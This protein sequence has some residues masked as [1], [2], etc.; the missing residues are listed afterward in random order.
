[1]IL[2][3]SIN[4]LLSF[5]ILAG[6]TSACVAP[7]DSEAEATSSVQELKNGAFQVPDQSPLA[8]STVHVQRN[9]INNPYSCT[10]VI[11]GAKWV[12]TAAHC[13]IPSSLSAQRVYFYNGPFHTGDYAD[14]ISAQVPPGVVGGAQDPALLV[15]TNGKFADIEVLELSSVIPSYTRIAQ[16]PLLYPGNDV[17]GLM[18]GVGAHDE[19]FVNWDADM[20]QLSRATYSS[21]T[22]DG[23]FLVN[24]NHLLW[25][26]HDADQGDSGGPFLL[27]NN[28]TSRWV[29]Q[30]LASQPVNEWGSWKTKYA[31]IT[32]RLNWVLD[33]ISF[34]GFG[35]WR[36]VNTKLTG[37]VYSSFLLVGAQSRR[38]AL[39]CEHNP[40]CVGYSH[41]G[42]SCSLYSAST[43]T[44]VAVGTISGGKR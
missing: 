44:S 17:T 42:V 5:A 22:Q 21:D 25:E 24:D 11:V 20:R 16:L 7:V 8:K 19:D 34:Q 27:F 40:S 29:V 37:T 4:V 30:G 15:D 14:V 43:G 23:H 38:C 35:M 32:H 6:A 1:M 12:L 36:Q 39:Y 41:N 28:T 26:G 9:D 2:R 3:H 18:T 10:G 33:A 13:V 31:S